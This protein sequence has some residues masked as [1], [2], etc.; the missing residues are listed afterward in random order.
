MAPSNIAEDIVEIVKINGII[1]LQVFFLL[2]PPFLS[3]SL[4]L[5]YTAPHF[6]YN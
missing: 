6:F 5:S 1:A 4:C 3:L 2:V